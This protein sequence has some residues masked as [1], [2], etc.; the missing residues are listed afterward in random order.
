M[1]DAKVEWR[2]LE[3]PIKSLKDH[4]KNPRQIGKEQFERLGNQISKFGLI[5]KPVVNADFTIIGGHQRVK[6]YKKNKSKTI[7]CWVAD[8]QLSEKDVEEL[9]IGLNLHH[10]GWDWDILANE[11]DRLDL[12]SYGFTEEQLMDTSCEDVFDTEE[13]SSSKKKK[14][15]PN[16]GH[17]F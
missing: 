3:V 11:W 2:L 13:K 12:L 7:E 1:S 9:C 6:Y 15:C 16:C 5:D 17:E 10:G 4:E 8:R 14:E